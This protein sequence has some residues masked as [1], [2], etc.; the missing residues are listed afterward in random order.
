MYKKIISAFMA[1]SMAITVTPASTV[2]NK[3]HE[4]SLF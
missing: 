4:S 2:I 3:I 1:I